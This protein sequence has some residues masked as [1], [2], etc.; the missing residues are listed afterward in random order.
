MQ[1]TDPTGQ[2]RGS[3]VFDWHLRP[4]CHRDLLALLGLQRARVISL[5]S[6]QLFPAERAVH[7]LSLGTRDDKACDLEAALD[8]ACGRYESALAEPQ[9]PLATR[10][11]AKG[12]AD[13]RRADWADEY[14]GAVRVP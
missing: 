10:H 1:I 12:A 13:T 2:R 8:R 6:E 14:P 7:Q 3:A 4:R 11:R 5:R 9:L